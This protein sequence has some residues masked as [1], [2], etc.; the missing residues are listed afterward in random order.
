MEILSVRTIL[1][2]RKRLPLMF[3]VKDITYTSYPAG[4]RGGGGIPGCFGGYGVR[5][6]SGIL[7]FLVGYAD[8]TLSL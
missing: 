7:E 4:G 1:F 8:K 6:W 3:P 2:S 5:G